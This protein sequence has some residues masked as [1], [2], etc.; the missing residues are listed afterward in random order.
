MNDLNRIIESIEGT[1]ALEGL[2]LTEE[3]YQTLN[4][5]HDGQTTPEQEIERLNEYY[6][7]LQ[8]QEER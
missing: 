6:K 1:L 7:G 4:R 2:Y 5:I 3:D 8:K